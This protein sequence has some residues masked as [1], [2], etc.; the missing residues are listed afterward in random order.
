M[1]P[2]FFL[3]A[4]LVK[5][6][7]RLQYGI[8]AILG[9]VGARMVAEEALHALHIEMVFSKQTLT[10]T[11]LGVILGILALS[12]PASAVFKGDEQTHHLPESP[13][14]GNSAQ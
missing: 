3:L 1:R 14:G 13:L 12:V 7:T 6:F 9:F 10:F 11:S 2:L 8:A 5:L 4:G